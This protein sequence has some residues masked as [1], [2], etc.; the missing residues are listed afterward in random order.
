MTSLCLGL[1]SA[2]RGLCW[3]SIHLEWMLRSH[4]LA[5]GE[6]SGPGVGKPWVPL[7]SVLTEDGVFK[8]TTSSFPLQGCSWEQRPAP[9]V[10][11]P[12]RLTCCLKPWLIR[13]KGLPARGPHSHSDH[14]WVTSLLPA[15]VRSS[16]LEA[17]S[18]GRATRDSP[19]V[20][21]PRPPTP[22]PRQR[23]YKLT[24]KE[25]LGDRAGWVTALFSWVSWYGSHHILGMGS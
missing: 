10:V 4:E 25:R 16:G 22:H 6:N 5:H 1:T 14:S 20:L 15:P 13:G 24:V 9:I 21:Q 23:S 12:S 17:P 19:C 18:Q 3:H 8:A 7:T 2:K 11:L